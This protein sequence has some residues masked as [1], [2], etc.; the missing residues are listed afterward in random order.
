[1]TFMKSGT[2]CK[3]CGTK[4]TILKGK[5]IRK[6]CAKC[7]SEAVSKGLINAKLSS[8]CA[9]KTKYTDERLMRISKQKIGKKFSKLHKLH[10][11]ESR[12]NKHLTKPQ[13]NSI[14][15][16][17][18][19][20]RKRILELRTGKTL[21]EFYGIKKA[22]IVREKMKNRKV[23]NKGIHQWEGKN[24][25]RGMPGKHHSDKTKKRLRYTAT[26]E[27]RRTKQLAGINFPMMGKT[28]NK[29]LNNIEKE[30]GITL[31]R[32]YQILNYFIDGYN[33]ELNIA[34]EIDEEHHKN[35]TKYDERREDDIIKEIGCLFVR[36]DDKGNLKSINGDNE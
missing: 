1:M 35:R 3:K 12:K 15:N 10:L 17:G 16:A 2:Y 4:Y 23:W 5:Y 28:E 27:L 7:F 21:E 25:P 18:K 13:L 29:L 30:F 26:R 11:S 34:F 31:I 24:H 14:L 33:K 9:G 22:K 32:Q 36:I 20:G 8:W 19:I 6:R